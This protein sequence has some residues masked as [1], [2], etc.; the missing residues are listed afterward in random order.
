MLSGQSTCI[1]LK[2][3]EKFADAVLSC[4]KDSAKIREGEL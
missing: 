1:F 3:Y 4:T 2:I